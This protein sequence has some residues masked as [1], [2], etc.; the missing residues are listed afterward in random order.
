MIKSI[1]KEKKMT[2]GK[3]STLSLIK[4]DMKY[5]LREVKKHKALYNEIVKISWRRDIASYLKG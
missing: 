5:R 2:N 4:K 3:S 1:E